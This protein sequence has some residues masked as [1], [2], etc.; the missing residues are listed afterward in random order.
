MR[1]AEWAASFADPCLVQTKPGNASFA[2]TE[3]GFRVLGLQADPAR[4]RK[5]RAL[6]HQILLL[7]RL[8]TSRDMS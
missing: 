2:S 1:R 5:V 3:F 6:V 7:L 8:V 4:P